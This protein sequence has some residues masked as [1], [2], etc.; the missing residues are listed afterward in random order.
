MTGIEHAV[1]KLKSRLYSPT[2][3]TFLHLLESAQIRISPHKFATIYHGLSKSYNS[4]CHNI[5]MY[6]CVLDVLRLRHQVFLCK[7]SLEEID[8]YKK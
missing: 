7:I 5:A 2:A 3:E 8:Q 6:F 1:I 4:T